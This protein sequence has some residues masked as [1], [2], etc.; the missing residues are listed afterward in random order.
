LDFLGAKYLKPSTTPATTPMASPASPAPKTVLK[1]ASGPP[2]TRFGGKIVR[3]NAAGEHLLILKQKHRELNAIPQSRRAAVVGKKPRKDQL[4]SGLAAD[5][6]IL[7]DAKHIRLTFFHKL[8]RLKSDEGPRERPV[9]RMPAPATFH[10]LA[11]PR[12]YRPRII[13]KE[14]KFALRKLGKHVSKNEV[15][16]AWAGALEF[17]HQI[18]AE[19]PPGA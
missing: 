15:K 5:R 12:G 8:W 1:P 6:V 18:V 19:R 3:H 10:W 14:Q 11:F 17:A 13:A 2:A 9:S 4:Y 16:R 7:D